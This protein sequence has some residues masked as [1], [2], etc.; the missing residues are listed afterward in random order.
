MKTSKP[1]RSKPQLTE[2]W[3]TV[4][5]DVESQDSSSSGDEETPLNEAVHR[6]TPGL[7]KSQ[8]GLA[9]RRVRDNSTPLQARSTGGLTRSSWKS[10]SG[11]LTTGDIPN[12]DSQNY[13][14]S[15]K[16]VVEPVAEPEFIMPLVDDEAGGSWYGESPR[17][18][19][20]ITRRS[21]RLSA[22]LERRVDNK[23][24]PSSSKGR[25]TRIRAKRDGFGGSQPSQYP[26][27]IYSQFISPTFRFLAAILLTAFSMAK[28]FIVY[29]LAIWLLV[30]LFAYARN[31]VSSSINSALSPICLVPGASLLN[32]PFCDSIQPARPSGPVEFDKLIA[33]QSAFEDVLFASVDS[34]QLPMD[35]KRSEASVRDLKTVVKYSTLPSRNELVWEFDGFVETARQASAGLSKFNSHIGGAVDR[36]LSTNRWTLQVIDGITDTDASRGSVSKFVS[37]NLNI[38]AALG[39]RRKL[40]QEILRDQYLAHT[41]KIEEQ[42]TRLI[43]EAQEL[44]RDLE[45]LDGRLETISEI[46]T[47]DG[48]KVQGTKEE[49]L[50]ELWTRLGGKKSTVARLQSQLDLL[51]QVS[52]YRKMA[53]AHVASTIVKLQ[54]I[55]A[56]LESL[57]E[58]VTA[59]EVVGTE[60]VPLEVH[61]RNIELG[62][63]RLERQRSESRQVEMNRSRR[64]LDR[65]TVGE[66]RMIGG[67]RLG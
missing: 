15:T 39:P 64:I 49:L 48:I 18:S 17:T 10:R 21:A 57:K 32:L 8:P 44:L 47:R 58:S 61:I 13:V 51:N 54:A 12:G 60:D 42:I 19:A 65:G 38:F 34:G 28:P 14:Q 3:A 16:R 11:G 45:N 30:R 35:M 33:A 27:L 22:A 36:I 4:E 62:V 66:D 41:S 55:A 37:D 50:A 29:G 63:E 43:G 6:T 59:P 40:S 56:D 53:W 52:A 24:A 25:R 23:E 20:H 5:D 46:A 31:T 1:R 2:S 7:S 67:E 9:R 26:Q